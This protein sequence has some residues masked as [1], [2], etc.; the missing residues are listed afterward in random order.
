MELLIGCNNKKMQDEVEKN[1]QSY[2]I[3]LLNS[4]VST[5]ANE[6]IK[7][8]SCSYKMSV[9]DIFIAATALFYSLELYTDNKKH[10][11]FIKELTLFSHGI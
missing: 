4:Q 2:K 5:I 1:L 10:F 3:L 7:K 8:Y 9:A 11:D 6:I